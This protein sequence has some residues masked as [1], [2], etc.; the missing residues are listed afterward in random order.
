MRGI[1]FKL[2]N[3]EVYYHD[4]VSNTDFSEDDKQYIIKNGIYTYEYPKDNIESYEWYDMCE[5][6]ERELP[7][8]C[9]C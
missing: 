6:C 4:P 5:K 7:N 3:G 2:K 1:K 9:E 8:Y